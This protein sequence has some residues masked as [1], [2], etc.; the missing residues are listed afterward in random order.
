MYIS[1][2]ILNNPNIY[3]HKQ[4]LLTP[5]VS[6]F[7]LRQQWHPPKTC[8]KGNF[9]HPT[10]FFVSCRTPHMVFCN[11]SPDMVPTSNH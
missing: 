2:K 8:P 7:D 11:V 6:C 10:W 1:E 3:S 4:L 5:Q 9:Y